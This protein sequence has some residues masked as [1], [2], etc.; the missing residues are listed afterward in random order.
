MNDTNIKNKDLR[1][2]WLACTVSFLFLLPFIIRIV[3]EW[4][5]GLDPI[6]QTDGAFV[7]FVFIP[8]QFIIV[9]ICF[10]VN[11]AI[12]VRW[13]KS[14]NKKLNIISIC[15]TFPIILLWVVMI[16]NII[17]RSYTL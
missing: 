10:Y 3:R 17:Y 7:L 15:L 8:I 13:S 5:F 11:V 1:L 12:F 9:V 14:K 2:F 6:S 4:F 16:A